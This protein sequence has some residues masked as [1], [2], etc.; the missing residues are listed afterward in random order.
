M[1]LL[2]FQLGYSALIGAGVCILIMIPLQFLIGKKMSS[3]SKELMVRFVW[4]LDS[5]HVLYL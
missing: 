2:Y 1:T 4:R 5:E 3:N